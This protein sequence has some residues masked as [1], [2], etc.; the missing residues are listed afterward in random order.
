MDPSDWLIDTDQVR[1]STLILLTLAALGLLVGALLWLGVI[2]RV[3]GVAGALI[4]GGIRAGFRAWERLLAWASWPLF[5]AVQL[6]L[7]AAGAAAAG[8][9][10]VLDRR[11][12]P[13]P[14]GMGLAA[15]LAYMFIDVERYEVARGYKALHDP[16]KGQR[17]ADRPRPLRRP[18]R[19]PPARGRG[20]RDDRRVRPAQLRPLPPA[21]PCLVYRCRRPTRPT[22]TSWRRPWSTS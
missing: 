13:G 8:S 17:L 19:G 3:L 7:L 6:G 5:L 21:R 1:S 10:P 11:L 4:R 14:L 18:G 22:P 12:R 2:D 15:C 9:L 16:L 20:R